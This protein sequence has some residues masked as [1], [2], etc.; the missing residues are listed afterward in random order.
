LYTLLEKL[1]KEM[2]ITIIMV[3]HDLEAVEKYATKILRMEDY[4]AC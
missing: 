4:H 3:S 1:N 2:S